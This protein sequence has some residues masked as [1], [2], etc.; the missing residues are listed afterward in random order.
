M[1]VDPRSRI[2]KDKDRPPERY[3]GP[4]GRVSL[5]VCISYRAREK[6]LSYKQ[7]WQSVQRLLSPHCGY[8][9]CTV[10]DGCNL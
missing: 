7:S 4:G 10:C 3:V 5:C 9:S 6:A 1:D 8:T 2:D